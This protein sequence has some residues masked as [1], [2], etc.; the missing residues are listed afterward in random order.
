MKR[1]LTPFLVAL[2]LL[3]VGATSV[4]ADAVTSE[5]IAWTYNFTPVTPAPGNPAL[6]A[7]GST[8]AGVSFTN[9]IDRSAVGGSKSIVATNL[10]AFGAEGATY[11]FEGGRAYEFSMKI[12]SADGTGTLNFKGTISGSFSSEDSQLENSFDADSLKTKKLTLGDY[13]FNV[14]LVPQAILPGPANQG[15]QGSIAVAVTVTKHDPS[16]PDPAATPE[17]STMLM[18][19]LGLTF[20][21]GAAWRKRRKV[22]G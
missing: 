10:K 7:D 14:T 4:Y 16:D 17:P 15:I 6:Y 3:S 1:I 22:E 20:L 2:M 11:T 5:P 8:S 19:G 13:D 9:D 12:S 21:G 18:A